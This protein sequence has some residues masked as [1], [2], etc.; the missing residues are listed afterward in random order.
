AR[1][2]HRR[3]A[4]TD[5]R[6]AMS[7]NYDPLA[8]AVNDAM[9]PVLA[10]MAGDVL[11]AALEGEELPTHPDLLVEATYE[12]HE[13]LGLLWERLGG[14]AERFATSGDRTELDTIRLAVELMTTA[15]NRI[16]DQLE[17]TT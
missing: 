16:I 8:E 10:E 14:S 17:E 11:V 3:G 9:R 1:A 15:A 5:R 13:A 12:A 4:A 7:A 2:V 6:C